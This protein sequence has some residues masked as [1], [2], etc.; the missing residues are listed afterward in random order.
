MQDFCYKIKVNLGLA[1]FQESICFMEYIFN[2]IMLQ[3]KNLEKSK[4]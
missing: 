1:A 2:E 4:S 3:V